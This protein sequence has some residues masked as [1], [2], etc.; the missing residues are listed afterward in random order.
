MCCL[1]RD[2]RGTNTFRGREAEKECPERQSW[3][4]HPVGV[5]E[6]FGTVSKRHSGHRDGGKDFCS[7]EVRQASVSGYTCNRFARRKVASGFG[8][9]L[10]PPMRAAIM[11]GHPQ[12]ERQYL[13]PPL[14]HP[15]AYLETPGG[16]NFCLINVKT[17]H[18]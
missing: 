12:L 18:S 6:S 9:R 5:C 3:I 1:G 15:T 16:R 13:L 17:P 2:C 4:R 10:S 11:A 8:A 14:L 7:L